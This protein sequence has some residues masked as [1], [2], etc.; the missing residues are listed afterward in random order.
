MSAELVYLRVTDSSGAVF[1]KYLLY[2][3]VSANPDL[4]G[5]SSGEELKVVLKR[6]L[7]TSCPNRSLSFTTWTQTVRQSCGFGPPALPM[8]HL[9]R[10]V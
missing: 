5:N 4:D 1:C 8:S 10:W 3:S 9:G 6:K 7:R 2:V